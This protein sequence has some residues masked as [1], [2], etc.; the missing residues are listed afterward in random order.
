MLIN[1][2]LTSVLFNQSFYLKESLLFKLP[3]LLLIIPTLI[4]ASLD[5][6]K[7]INEISIYKIIL[8]LIPVTITHVLLASYLIQFVSLNFLDT[9]FTFSY[10][11][12]TKFTQ[13][14]VFIL[15]TYG[16]MYLIARYYHLNLSQDSKR[17]N[18]TLTIKTG[19]RI[20]TINVVDI[21]WIAAETPYIAIWVDEY[22]YLYHS[23]L[24]DILNQLDHPD[25]IRIHRSTIVNITRISSLESRQN[26]DYDIQLYNNIRLRLS[27][28]YRT[29]N[30]DSQLRI[31]IH[32][33]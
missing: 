4:F 1:D 33:S 12:K 14:F 25:F 22:K 20:D 23:T 16:L 5:K 6:K 29:P 32:T 10:L 26:G 9:P 21:D 8:M 11:I 13:D 2:Y 18:K 28:T 24:T 30:I 7:N 17:R 15:T 27:R 3:I 19:T 31:K